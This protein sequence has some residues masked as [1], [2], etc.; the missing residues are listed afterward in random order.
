MLP[1]VPMLM[2]KI[3]P[4]LCRMQEMVPVAQGPGDGSQLLGGT[5][6]WD[7]GSLLAQHWASWR[8]WGQ[9]AA[10]SLHPHRGPAASVRVFARGG[11]RRVC[12]G[13][14]PAARQ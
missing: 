1:T 13:L 9:E 2:L 11:V 8:P 4:S 10:P 5:A 6:H 14:E 7:A 12:C 3:R